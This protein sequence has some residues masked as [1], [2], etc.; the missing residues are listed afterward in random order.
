MEEKCSDSD[1]FKE[2]TDAAI[3]GVWASP[4]YPITLATVIIFL[5]LLIFVVAWR[6]AVIAKIRHRIDES[7][8][9]RLRPD[10]GGRP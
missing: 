9:R 2:L 6:A 10:F 4:L 1:Y 5:I 8:A 7:T 3:E